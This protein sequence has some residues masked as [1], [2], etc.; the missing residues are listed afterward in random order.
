MLSDPIFIELFFCKQVTNKLE[1]HPRMLYLVLVTG[2]HGY[3]MS[4][5]SLLLPNRKFS[6]Q[7]FSFPMGNVSG[8]F[9]LRKVQL[10]WLIA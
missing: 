10:I 3:Y 6:T 2:L 7:L 9:K 5:P 8:D 1:A 4:K